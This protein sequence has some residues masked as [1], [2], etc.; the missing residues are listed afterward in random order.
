MGKEDTVKKSKSEYTFLFHRDIVFTEWNPHLRLF[1]GAVDLN[2]ILKKILMNEW[3]EWMNEFNT[4]ISV[5]HS[6]RTLNGG[7]L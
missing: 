4:K 3:N 6:N 1:F 5:D 2:A 7:Q